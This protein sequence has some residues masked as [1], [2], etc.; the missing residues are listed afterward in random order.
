MQDLI[1]VRV[2]ETHADELT[3][4]AKEF[5]KIGDTLHG[6]P[7]LEADKCV[8]E[9]IAYAHSFERE[10]TLPDPKFVT[11]TQ[12]VALRKDDPRIFGVVNIRH[13][14]NDALKEDGGYV[15]YSTRP[16]ER[17]KGYAT[18]MLILALN[19]FRQMGKSSIMISCDHDNIASR[20][21][22]ESC[23]GVFE[24]MSQDGK[25]SIFWINL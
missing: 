11:A 15:G 10:D 1:L 7:F 20:K 24:R 8:N 16:S 13:Y 4:Y 19:I 5:A 21:T 3:Q 14:L 18:A 17:K 9:W 23:G 25:T 2:D 6:A 22:I 12:Y